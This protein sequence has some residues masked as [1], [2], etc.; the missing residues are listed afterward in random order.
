MKKTILLILSVL[1][2]STTISGCDLVVTMTSEKKQT[3]EE[4]AL[5]KVESENYK[6]DAIKKVIKQL[7]TEI[8]YFKDDK[9]IC[10][11][12]IM[13]SVYLN[14]GHEIHGYNISKINVS[15]IDCTK[16]EL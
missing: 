15:T 8:N 2:L 6:K 11:G 1:L 16:A 3:I 5:E 13:P 12:F 7:K 4:I 9:G 10:W 14:K